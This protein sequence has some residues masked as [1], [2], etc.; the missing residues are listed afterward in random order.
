[1]SRLF[2]RTL[3]AAALAFVAES[4]PPVLAQSKSDPGKEPPDG[5][6]AMK[7]LVRNAVTGAAE[8]TVRVRSDDKNVALGTILD[9]KGY[10][11]TKGSELR[12]KIA[13]LL[14]N[15]DEYDAQYIGYH[16]PSDLALLKIDAK[17]LH[18]VTI[19]DGK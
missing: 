13:I 10:I 12:S 16:E 2:R 14:H 19:A 7:Y 11:L 1:M 9:E 18:A 8:S 17:K 15:G 6:I 5:K 4:S 3:L